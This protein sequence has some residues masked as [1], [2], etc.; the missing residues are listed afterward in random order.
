MRSGRKVEAALLMGLALVSACAS[1][2][3]K[4]AVVPPAPKTSQTTPYRP[5]A[6]P[7]PPMAEAQTRVY[8]PKPQPLDER[9]I[10]MVKPVEPPPAP[11]PAARTAARPAPPTAAAPSA[12]LPATPSADFPRPRIRPVESEAERRR[13]VRDVAARRNRTLKILG[14][15]ATRPLRDAQRETFARVQAFLDQ[16]EAA[17][18]E[19][20]LRQA[21]ELSRRA[22][23]LA[24]DLSRGQ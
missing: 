4:S 7:E 17:L 9:A 6:T 24:Q 20:D 12:P 1:R 8:L 18:K 10:V 23:L 16:A 5:A 3:P 2:K 19:N 21:D 14:D 13:I 15:L 22:L 11:P